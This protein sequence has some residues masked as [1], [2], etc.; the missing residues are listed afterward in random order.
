LAYFAANWRAFEA[1]AGMKIASI[2]SKGPQNVHLTSRQV[3]RQ[4]AVNGGGL[5]S[6]KAIEEPI[7][8]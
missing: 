1:A 3:R 5:V 4:L 8:R 6:Q 2:D 7:P